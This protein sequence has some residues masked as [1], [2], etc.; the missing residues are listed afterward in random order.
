[1]LAAIS[2]TRGPGDFFGTKQSGLPDFRIA[3]MVTD[4]ETMEQARD[5]AA[6]LVRR[7][8]FWTAATYMPLRQY[9]QR[10]HIFDNDLLD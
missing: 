5:D 10:E 7:P 2:S 6:E 8:E 9:L 1:M 4:F 3:D